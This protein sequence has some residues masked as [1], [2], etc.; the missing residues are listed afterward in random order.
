MCL[1]SEIEEFIEITHGKRGSRETA[2]LIVTESALQLSKLHSIFSV[3]THDRFPVLG[4]I[5]DEEEKREE[6]VGASNMHSL[7]ERD[8]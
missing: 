5:V 2:G 3:P 6:S 1:T 7:R 8:P 4:A